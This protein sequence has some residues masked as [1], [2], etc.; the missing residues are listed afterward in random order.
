MPRDQVAALLEGY[1]ERFKLPVS[2]NTPV[3]S[4]ERLATDGAFAV[5]TPNREWHARNVV[6]AT[7]FFQKPQ[8]P[9][10]GSQLPP[11]IHQL[12]SG[13]YRNSQSLPPGAV[14][15]VGSGQ[16]GC[17]IAEDLHLGGRRVYLAVGSA[18]RTV[19]RYR[20]RDIYEWLKLVGFFDR[21]PNMLP[22]PRARF[23][24][25]PH[26]SGGR[27]GHSISLHQFA[28]DGIVLLGHLQAIEGDAIALAPDLVEMM[29][30]AD[31]FLKEQLRQIDTYIAQRGLDAPRDQDPGLYDDYVPPVPDKLNLRDAEIGS[32]IWA[33]GFQ[34]DYR[35]IRSAVL[36]EFG[37]PMA[38]PGAANVPG[39]Y[40][41]GLP[42]LPRL[43]TALLSGIGVAAS[44]IA[45]DIVAHT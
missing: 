41:L 30:K 31:Q 28:R 1:P 22:S 34:F 9:S 23:A 20:G 44:A 43:E 16:S 42:W 24:A 15:V 36:D 35:W 33:T 18:G 45:E 3:T 29:E 40:F 2:Y 19:R 39:L 25:L 8:I 4:V 10:V 7:G 12:T 32:V 14:L 17:Q 21:T 11:H 27:G 6:V 5:R 13:D 38:G 26:L 37:Y